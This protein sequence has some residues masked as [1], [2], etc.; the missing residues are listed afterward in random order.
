[1]ASTKSVLDFS[2]TGAV[3]R[4]H[5]DSDE[6]ELL[7]GLNGR[8]RLRSIGMISSSSTSAEVYLVS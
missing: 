5:I 3:E 4:V 1:M 6:T 7:S 2:L 8:F